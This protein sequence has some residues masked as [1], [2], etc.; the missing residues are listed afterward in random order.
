MIT[1]IHKIFILPILLTVLTASSS[2]A[3]RDL[4]GQA[5]YDL[6]F[7]IPSDT[8]QQVTCT[9][10]LT[11][12]LTERTDVNLVFQGTLTGICKVN[13][14]KRKLAQTSNQIRLPRKMV[15][16]GV[17]E[18]IISY[19]CPD[20]VFRRH[21]NYIATRIDADKACMCFPVFHQTGLRARF[22]THIKASE[23]WKTMTPHGSS[24]IPPSLYSMVTGNF[25]EQTTN[26]N[27]RQ[28]RI[29]YQS[30]E[31]VQQNAINN[32]FQEAGHA[33]DWMERYTGIR[34]PFPEYGIVVMPG[35]P[36][37]AA[38]QPGVIQLN[39]RYA[40]LSGRP[41]ANDL[42]MRKELIT[43][44]TAHLWFGGIVSMA[45]PADIWAE[46]VLADFL[47]RR[48]NMTYRG[49]PHPIAMMQESLHESTAIHE[50]AANVKSSIIMEIIEQQIGPRQLQDG[51]QMFL[52]THYCKD[53]SWEDLLRILDEISPDA[54]VIQLGQS[55][56]KQSD[57][58]RIHITCKDNKL[59]ATQTDPDGKPSCWPQKFDVYL[60]NDTTP[61]RTITVDMRHPTETIEI[62][63]QPGYII[64][65]FS[66]NGYGIFT[67]DEEY[68][69]LLPQRLMITRNDLNRYV[70]LLTL[71]DNYR[72]GRLPINYFS[73]LYR[74]MTHEHNSLIMETCLSHMYKLIGD[75]PEA[76]RI[77]MEKCIV[78]LLRENRNSDCRRAVI[79]KMAQ[80][81]TS[82]EALDM[83]Y[84]IWKAHNDP[85]LDDYDY[86]E[87]ALRLNTMRKNK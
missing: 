6:T 3:A 63:E 10:I 49:A 24:L 45:H 33:I 48:C 13:G 56:A 41:S 12:L 47:T 68:T 39:E 40:M 87:I 50:N 43:H 29:L 35:H 15:R 5:S 73:E 21:P 80:H 28:M 75:A 84:K 72:L 32:L 71:Y 44:E 23:G 85:L 53:A 16:K 77:P 70:L 27:G 20:E 2:I 30:Q 4:I 82:Y 60:I 51:L 79:R 8:R 34:C 1:K 81:A 38:S 76:N 14:R 78:E 7:R 18:L 62:N 66:G 65:N 74:N 42:K 58:P 52:S 61:C 57:K 59:T 69:Q 22:T 86:Q 25:K 26:Q 64:P 9:T 31:S 46:E 54:G 11:F 17:N 19:I 36:T 55:W 83:L 67:L 37:V